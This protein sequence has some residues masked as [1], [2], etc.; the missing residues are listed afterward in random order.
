[1]K[2]FISLLV[3]LTVF[4]SVEMSVVKADTISDMVASE[5]NKQYNQLRRKAKGDKKKLSSLLSIRKATLKK[6]NRTAGLASRPIAI[7]GVK[8]MRLV[9]KK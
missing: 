9:V 8:K 3:I 7:T 5:F 2:K 1:M 6:I 4:G